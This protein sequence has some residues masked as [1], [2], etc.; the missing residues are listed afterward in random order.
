MKRLELG[1]CLLSLLEYTASTRKRYVPPGRSP[2]TSCMRM[3][4]ATSASIVLHPPRTA[5]SPDMALYCTLKK[6]IVRPSLAGTVHFNITDVSDS[7]ETSG[8]D[9]G[10]SLA[11][12]GTT[13]VLYYAMI[14]VRP[15][16]LRTRTTWWIIF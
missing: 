15:R 13:N 7:F 14:G 3:S 10:T 4:L 2:E 8:F 16:R 1:P 12:T 11:A 9:G 5:R 6:V